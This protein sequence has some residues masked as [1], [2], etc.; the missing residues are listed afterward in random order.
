MFTIDWKSSSHRH[1]HIYHLLLVCN[2]A[3]MH[4]RASFKILLIKTRATYKA[5][6][7]YAACDDRVQI[8]SFPPSKIHL[9]QF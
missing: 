1:T 8:K 6:S 7:S 2:H 4:V 5:S 3:D 9:N